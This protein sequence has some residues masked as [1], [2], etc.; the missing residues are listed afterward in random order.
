[1]TYKRGFTYAENTSEEENLFEIGG[2]NSDL[3]A[4]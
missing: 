3:L 2:I 4:I 1:M